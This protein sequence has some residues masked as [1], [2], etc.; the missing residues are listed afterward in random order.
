MHNQ[1]FFIQ[2]A[3]VISG[4]ALKISVTSPVSYRFFIEPV[5]ITNMNLENDGASLPQ[6]DELVAIK[7]IVLVS[8]QRY[9]EALDFINELIKRNPFKKELYQY[10]I[11]IYKNMNRQDLIEAEVQKLTN[12]ADGL[13]LDDLLNK[14]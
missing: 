12:F 14:N 5:T 2:I 7:C 10:R 11:T 4:S 3:F 1:T 8:S 13:S 9:N 6:S